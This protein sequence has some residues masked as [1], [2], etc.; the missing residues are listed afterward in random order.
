VSG[1]AALHAAAGNVTLDAGGA[2]TVALPATF[3][4]AC[5]T[6]TLAVGLTAVGAA[7]P[8]LFVTYRQKDG[9]AA[10]VRDAFVV[11]GGIAGG[12]VAWTAWATRRAV[13]L[14]KAQTGQAAAGRTAMATTAE[15]GNDAAWNR[16][17]MPSRVDRRELRL[18][19]R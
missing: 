1:E 19:V 17:S 14:Q 2:A 13:E 5:D 6:T 11:T 9:A 12:A 16:R 8:G 7:M 3:A 18:P 15:P 10:G 4:A